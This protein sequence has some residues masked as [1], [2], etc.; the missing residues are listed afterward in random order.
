[1]VVWSQIRIPNAD[2][3]PGGLKRAITVGNN[4][5]KRQIIRH[6]KDK[7]QC[8]WY[9]KDKKQCNWYKRGKCYFIFIKS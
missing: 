3:D 4:A 9:K 2:P 6:K 5:S 7:K 8:N 1:M